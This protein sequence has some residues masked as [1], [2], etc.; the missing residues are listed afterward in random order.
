MFAMELN[1][2]TSAPN[3]HQKPYKIGYVVVLIY[4]ETPLLR[5]YVPKAHQ[6]FESLRLRQ[7]ETLSN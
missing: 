4:D 5:E 2:K 7:Y 3:L 6:G 1:A